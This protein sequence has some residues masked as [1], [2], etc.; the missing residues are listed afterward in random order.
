MVTPPKNHCPSPKQQAPHL[1]QNQQAKGLR[2]MQ[3]L[4]TNIADFKLQRFKCH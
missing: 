4:R 3:N 2:T 1:D